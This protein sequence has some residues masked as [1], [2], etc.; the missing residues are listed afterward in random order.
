MTEY[1]LDL[2][3]DCPRCGT[4]GPAQGDGNGNHKGYWRCPNEDC[5][6]EYFVSETMEFYRTGSKNNVDNRST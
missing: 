5:G 6:C 1:V 2:E 4:I 3:K